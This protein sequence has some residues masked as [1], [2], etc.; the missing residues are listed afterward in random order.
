MQRKCG[1]ILALPEHLLSFQLSGLQRLADNH[2]DESAR[3]IV[4]QDWLKRNCRDVLDECDNILAIRTQLIYPSGAQKVVDGH[5][6]RWEVVQELLSRIDGHLEN[7]QKEF[8]TGIEV[9]R[10]FEGAFPMAYFLK[11]EVEERLT[12]RLVADVQFQR[13]QILPPDCPLDT[14]RA[15]QHFISEPR[16]SA[17]VLETIES[18]Y[19]DKP[20]VKQILYLLRGLFVHRL[21]VMVLKKRWNVQYGLHPVRD[22]IAVPYLA[23][24]TPSEQSE[25]GHPDVMIIMTCL[26]FYYQGLTVTQLR[27]ALEHIIKSDDPAQAY[28]RIA[29]SSTLPD[30][31]REWNAI[32]VDDEA[33]V[34]EIW[35]H[36]RYDPSAINHF[37]NNF[38]FPQHAKQ[39]AVK[40]QGCGWDLPLWAATDH[41]ATEGNLV[42]TGFSGTNDWKRLLPLTIVQRDLPSLSHTNAEVLCYLLEGRNRQV[43]RAADSCGRHILERDLLEKIKLKNIRILIDAGAQILEM[44]NLALCRTWLDVDTQARAALYFDESSKPWITYRDGKRLPHAVSPFADDL[45]N[46]LVYFDEAHTRGTDLKFPADAVGALTLGLN[47]TKD[48]TVQGTCL[49]TS[50]RQ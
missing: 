48:H 18:I 4:F 28:D 19:L 22:P 13:T 36:I 39:F 33:Q 37:L 47:Q 14:R 35:K 32:N 6:L 15:I 34:K 25:W 42:T 20:S 24:G 26:S 17:Q 31:L 46:C 27:Q 2:V 7:L 23:K 5:P 49:Q 38:V 3:M 9:V 10:R 30:S 12:T 50:H 40:L 21:L 1:V 16:P 44:D 8:P 11:R 41:N 29:S 43:I 45:S